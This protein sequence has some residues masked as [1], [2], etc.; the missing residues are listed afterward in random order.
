MKKASEYREYAEECRTLAK[1]LEGEHRDQLLDM[2]R[3][4]DKLASERADLHDLP[5]DQVQ[6]EGDDGPSARQQD[7]ER[8][9]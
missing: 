3:T 1:Q 6:D 7:S 4:W 8:A 9:L 5:S 2:A